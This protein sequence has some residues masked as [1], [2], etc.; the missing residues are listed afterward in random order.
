MQSF[1]EDLRVSQVELLTR[2]LGLLLESAQHAFN[3]RPLLVILQIVNARSKEE[4]DSMGEE[5]VDIAGFAEDFCDLLNF[6][7]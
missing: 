5:K 4:P 2:V 1:E 6:Q 3:P 7:R